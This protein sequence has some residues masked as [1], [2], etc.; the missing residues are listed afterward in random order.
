MAC[1][2]VIDQPTDHW[3]MS[4]VILLMGYWPM[5]CCQL[6]FQVI[7]QCSVIWPLTGRQSI[8][9]K[10]GTFFG[11]SPAERMTGDRGDAK[12]NWETP[13]PQPPIKMPGLFFPSSFIFA[14]PPPTRCLFLSLFAPLPGSLNEGS[15]GVVDCPACPF[16]WSTELFEGRPRQAAA[17]CDRAKHLVDTYGSFLDENTRF[18]VYIEIFGVTGH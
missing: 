18:F 3:Q 6:K 11:Q 13:G 9:W 7:D 17:A 10:L 14:F 5:T 12:P 4:P 1:F 2:W 15:V 16:S 8:N